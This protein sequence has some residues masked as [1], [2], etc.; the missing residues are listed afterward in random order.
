[1]CAKGIAK[2]VE[3]CGELQQVLGKRL[4]YWDSDHHWDGT[5]LRTRLAEEMGD[6]MAAIEF[7][8]DQFDIGELVEVQARMKRSVFDSWEASVGNNDHGIDA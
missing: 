8:A 1:M 3:E 5:N 4:A 7:V 2:L 6:V